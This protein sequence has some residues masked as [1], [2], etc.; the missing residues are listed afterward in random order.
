MVTGR[1]GGPC[2]EIVPRIFSFFR[3]YQVRVCHEVHVH[4]VRKSPGMVVVVD[5]EG[6][7]VQNY[8]LIVL[9]TRPWR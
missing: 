9:A 5:V 1:R 6:E 3:D 2:D 4:I 8:A 7:V